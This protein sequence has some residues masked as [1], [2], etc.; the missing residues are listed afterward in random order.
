MG[1]SD[2]WGNITTGT[3][4]VRRMNVDKDEASKEAFALTCPLITKADG[5]KFGK[6]ESGNIWLTAD[7]TSAYKFYQFWLNVSDEDAEKYIKIFTFLDQAT[8]NEIVEQHNE[9]KGMRLLQKRL[10]DEVTKFVHSQEDLDKAILA[11]NVLFGKAGEQDLQKL[12]ND[13]FLEL[14]VGVPQA[15]LNKDDLKEGID[16]VSLLVEKTKFLPS[17]REARQALADNSIAINKTKV[18]ENYRLSASNLINDEFVLL[19]RGKKNY[20]IVRFA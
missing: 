14:F 12:D 9:D 3:E 5:S 6:S 20:F 2:Q 4:L 8:I 16:M 7:K 18:D 11:S 17:N 19:Q 1:G 13:T 15:E 10:A